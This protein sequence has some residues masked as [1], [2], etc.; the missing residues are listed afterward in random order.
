VKTWR[1]TQFESA[2]TAVLEAMAE[3]FCVSTNE[4]SAENRCWIEPVTLEGSDKSTLKCL[5]NKKENYTLSASLSLLLHDPW[6]LH[7]QY[8]ASVSDSA[9]LV[10]RPYKRR[11]F[12][13]PHSH[14]YVPQKH[15]T[16]IA[17]SRAD[18]KLSANRPSLLLWE[19]LHGD[20]GVFSQF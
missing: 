16:S 4:R 10:A 12:S 14:H 6:N 9:D 3:R 5:L 7:P 13:E 19:P 1:I 18:G 11:T 20:V 15:Q 2:V 17:V 8:T